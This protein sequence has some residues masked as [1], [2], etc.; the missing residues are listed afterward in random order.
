MPG[1]PVRPSWY[2]CPQLASLV[3]VAMLLAASGLYAAEGAPPAPPAEA[4]RRAGEQFFETKVR[5]I[6][7][8]HCYKCHGPDRHKANLRLDSLHAMLAGGDSGPAIIAG[9]APHSLLVQVISY[10][11]DYVQ[12]P[13]TKK[14]PDALIADLTRWVQMGAPWPGSEHSQ[15]A[16]PRKAFEI[17]DRDRAY[18]FF[19]PI[20]R[21]SEPKVANATWASSPIDLFL[22]QS[23]EKKNLAPNSPATRRELIR[24]VFFDLIGLP[25]TPAEVERFVADPSPAAYENLLDELLARPQYGERWGRH[26][27][28]VVRFAQTNGY[29][30]DDEKPFA[31]RYRDYVVR[32]FNEDKPYNRFLIEQLA[33][34]ELERPS[35]ES[36]T[37]TGFY[38]LGV[39]DDEPDDARMAEFDGLDDVIVSTSAAFMGL[40]VGC[41]RC[42]DH[43][44]DPISQA[45][46]YR[47]LAFFRNVRPYQKPQYNESSATYVPLADPEKARQWYAAQKSQIAPLEAQMQ[48][49]KSEPERKQLKA[50]IGKLKRSSDAAPFDWALAVR[51]SGAKV[52]TT[53]V[54]IRGNAGTPG[55]EV[56]PAVLS[57]LGGRQLAITPP[58]GGQTSG[59]RLA[60]ARWLAQRDNPLPARV[61]ANRV[62][63]HHFGQGIVKSTN[64]FGHAGIPPT[65]PELLDWLAAELIESGWSVKH[66]H[67]AIMLSS[68]YRMSSRADNPRAVAAD[69][70]NDLLWRQNLRRLEA[71]SIRDTVLA[72]SG[73]LN[74][75]MGGRGFFPH[76]S[77]E[78]LAGSSKPGAGWELSPEREQTRRSIYTFVKRSL[79]DPMLETFDYSN[80]AQPLGERPVTTVAP[81]SLM[82]LNDDF[83]QTQA[84]AFAERLVRE[85]GSD[86]RQQI[87]LAYRLAVAREP[88]EREVALAVDYCGRQQPRFAALARRLTFRPD[89][90][91]S[92]ASAFLNRLRPTDLFVGPTH[93]WSYYRGRWVGVYEGVKT[94]DSL[95]G[96]FALWQGAVFA[97]GAIEGRMTLGEA[98]ELGSVILR[99]TAEGDLFRGYSVDFDSRAGSV[100]LRRHGAELTLLGEANAQLPT[101]QPLLVKIEARGPRIRVWVNGP[102][103]VLDITDPQPLNDSG[104]VGVASWGAGISLDGF[105]VDTVDRQLDLA[106]SPIMAGGTSETNGPLTGWQYFGGD[107]SATA[108]GGYGV[109]PIPG[110]KTIW[111]EPTLGDGLVEAEIQLRGTAGDA[112]L[113]LRVNQPTDGVD[114]LTAY[115][116]NFK[117][118]VVRIG[119]HENNWKQLVSAP[120]KW[121]TNRWHRV[122]VRLNG[123]RI[124][125][126]LDGAERPLLDFVDPNPL[127][128]GK[129]GLRTFNASF[130]VRNLK[131][132][133]G[134]HEWTADFRPKQPVPEAIG[135]SRPADANPRQQALQSLCLL[136]LNLNELVYID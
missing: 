9:D 18:W 116:I 23:L 34:D 10:S 17:T 98:S 125:V 50:K 68:A 31:W 105:V 113:I 13:P 14:L 38:R 131:V 122:Q 25:P 78:V 63:Q 49:A 76:L 108:D 123:P 120:R 89:V 19:Q 70:G 119:K 4:Q 92:L 75:A 71:E 91:F 93:G 40:T 72:V 135:A 130:A 112:G 29:E 118:N 57:V 22:L 128:A 95:R 126:Y 12:M 110:G 115:N 41:A 55:A 61:M 121:E 90:P 87:R 82:L 102:Q 27:L 36:L 51:E 69:P 21:A 81:Q 8:E 16:A 107:W 104:R 86:L 134:G 132:T 97:D 32:A 77:G 65:H 39:W 30:R 99:A 7:A 85:A 117:S 133:A 109:Q 94:V 59:R 37:A 83:V 6:L 111:L 127:P 5:P 62:W 96:P 54:L 3:A 88:T 66:L 45:D 46:Y 84:A 74:P 129:V 24:R 136:L 124:R 48:T 44:F 106:T 53:R 79:M 42:H 67:K 47:L 100:S 101:G 52:P 28:D 26:W 114:A 15:P 11:D 20:A 35:P 33:G 80:T 73:Q 60:L 64:D 2:A 103:P 58:A 43:M 1:Q 56:Q